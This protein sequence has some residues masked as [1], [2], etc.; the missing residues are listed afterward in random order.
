[1]TA[2]Q[3][4]MLEPLGTAFKAAHLP[5]ASRINPTAR[6]ASP[7]LPCMT[8]IYLHFLCAH[9]RLSAA[10]AG[11]AIHAIDLAKPRVFESVAV[12]PPRTFFFM[13]VFIWDSSLPLQRARARAR[14]ILTA[15]ARRRSAAGLSA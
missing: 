4:M 8:E 10:V 9:Y 1:M 2:S 6:N 11:V 13:C 7:T 3:A 15:M 12:V 14:E 5:P